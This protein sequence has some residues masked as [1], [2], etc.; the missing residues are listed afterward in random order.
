MDTVWIDE[1]KEKGVKFGFILIDNAEDLSN[2]KS[3]GLLGLG[4]SKDSEVGKTFLDILIENKIIQKKVFS[5]RL[6][7]N[8]RCENESSIIFGGYES[9]ISEDKIRYVNL[10]LENYWSVPISSLSLNYSSTYI[11]IEFQIKIKKICI[12]PK[13]IKTFSPEA[14]F[15]EL[16]IVTR[17]AIIDSGTTKVTFPRKDVEK[18][19]AGFAEKQIECWIGTNW[20][21]IEELEC[22][23]AIGSLDFSFDFSLGE[24]KFQLTS[25]N[26]IEQCFFKLQQF[27]F[28]CVLRI[29]VIDLED[30]EVIIMG[31]VFM[32]DHVIIFDEEKNRIGFYE[33][34]EQ[35]FKED[36][37]SLSITG[38]VAGV[39]IVGWI[40][41]LVNQLRR[42]N[43]A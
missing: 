38:I 39:S 32:K 30:L 12:I 20:Q 3:D 41:V 15:I 26:I 19:I 14:D 13:N 28:I 6:N 22:E 11:T 23:K 29:Q 8:Q 40:L 33:Q 10:S 17:H 18:I 36:H 43:L 5:L 16:E 21:G 7:P 37:R 24:H 25:K 42:Q 4:R 35:I 31:D 34:G 2:I 27:R 9:H 1:E